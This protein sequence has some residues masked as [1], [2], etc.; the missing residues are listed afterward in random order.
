VKT[1]ILTFSPLSVDEQSFFPFIHFLL[2]MQF[3]VQSSVL[4][5]DKT[6]SS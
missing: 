4:T 6:V 3:K 1:V 2:A 5:Q